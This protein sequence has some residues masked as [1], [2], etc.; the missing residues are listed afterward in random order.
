[1]TVDVPMTAGDQLFFDLSSRDTA[2]ATRL[3][4]FVVTTGT[5]PNVQTLPA[6]VHTRAAEGLFRNPTVAGRSPV[7]TATVRATR[8]R[9]TRSCSCSMGHTIRTTRAFTRSRRTWPRPAWGGPDEAAWVKAGEASSSRLGLDDIRMPRSEQF[10]GAGAVPRLSRSTNNSVSVGVTASEGTSESRLDFQDLNGD[11]F[12]DVIGQGGVQYSNM[13]GGLGATRGG[14][15]LGSARQSTNVA[16]GASTTL[17]GNNAVTIANAKSDAA[18]SG[19]RPTITAK[20][21]MDMPVLGFSANIGAGTAD[22]EHDLIDINGDGLP[23]K[24]Y[25]DGTVALNLGYSFAPAEPWGGGIVNHGQ[26]LDAGGGANLGFN[27]NH[28]SLAG[29]LSLTV[30][31]SK[32]NETY[33]DINGDGL[34]DKIV[35][36]TPLTVRLNT[37]TGFTAPIAWPGGHGHVA[38]DKHVSLGGGAYF[39]FG[40]YL[41]GRSRSSSIPVSTSRRTRAAPKSPS[42]TWTATASSTTSSPRRTASSGRAQP[43]RPHQPLEEGPPPARRRV[44]S[45]IHPRRQHLRPAAEPLAAHQGQRLRRPR[46]RGRRPAG[47]HLRLR[48]PAL[49]PPGREFLG[50]A[51][52][53]ST[54]TTPAPPA[55]PCTARSCATTSPTG[56]TPRAS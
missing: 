6:A 26:S 18:P 7:T 46:G 21:G 54:T 8:S 39:T 51:T 19:Q 35:A 25:K 45:R 14:A 1:M 37:G 33:T 38:M 50:Y 28:Y 16:V 47:H 24:V 22:T 44:R 48:G 56:S 43:D 10:A 29:G 3:T 27:R 52:V 31:M 5:D 40:F 55:I 42:A 12:P 15:G 11:R 20:Q 2:F 17:G 53:S 32:S 41:Y 49:P 23:D 13:R 36:G 30:G 9:S 4:T 34:P